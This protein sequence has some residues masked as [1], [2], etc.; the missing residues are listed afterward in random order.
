MLGDDL[1]LALDPVLFA[2][3]RLG[4][5]TPDPWQAE[6][7]RAQER[8]I[9]LNCHRQ[10]GKSTA[11]AI[12]ALHRAWFIPKSTVLLVSP[13]L[14]QS[15]E[16]FK[17]VSDYLDLMPDKPAFMPTD[18]QLS[19]ELPNGSRVISLPGKEG[20]IRGYSSVDLLIE[21]EASQ[22]DDSTYK[23]TRPMLAVSAG[24]HVLMSTPHGQR[25][26]FFTTWDKGGRGWKR[27]MVPVTFCKRISREFLAEERVTLGDLWYRQ[28]Y[29]CEFLADLNS[30]FP[31]DTIQQAFT[32]QV[33]AWQ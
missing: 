33:E 23:A 18:N 20:T 27:V 19:F 24:Q 14:R 12:K 16:L 5:A 31:L 2:G 3:D 26:H 17:K 22:V 4:F 29:M 21:D 7:L 13:S 30:I 9:L 15:S 11:A 6:F 25:G 32:P 28:E 8:Q 1:A 10:A